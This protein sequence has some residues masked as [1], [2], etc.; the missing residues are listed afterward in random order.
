MFNCQVCGNTYSAHDLLPAALVRDD[1]AQTIQARLPAWDAAGF[2][3]HGCLN[4]F[5][6]EYIRAE[7]EKN[8]GE[9]SALEEEVMHSLHG[10]ALV[11]DNLNAEFDSKLT[12]GER[13][14]DRVSAF[15]GSWRFIILFFTVL[16][17]PAVVML[18][19][20]P[21]VS[22]LTALTWKSAKFPVNPVPA[23]A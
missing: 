5:R 20:G 2:I 15:G 8:R 19:L 18:P 14:S 13:V 17:V 23:F 7:M 6:G 10:G 12:L 11:A 3:C 22:T 9:L 21:T 4:R 16:E 1:I